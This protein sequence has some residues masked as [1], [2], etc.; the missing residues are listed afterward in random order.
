VKE[1]AGE[2]FDKVDDLA[3]KALDEAKELAGDVK[4]A[5]GGLFSKIKKA[6]GRGD[7]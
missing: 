3:E 1:T 5:A 6:F 4:E 2:V 7:D